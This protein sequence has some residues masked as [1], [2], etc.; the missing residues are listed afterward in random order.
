MSKNRSAVHDPGMRLVHPE[1][2]GPDTTKPQVPSWP[3]RHAPGTHQSIIFSLERAILLFIAHT[4][5]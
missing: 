3:F 5:R 2:G 4:F 1:L